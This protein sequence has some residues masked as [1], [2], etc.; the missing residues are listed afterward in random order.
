MWII[1]GENNSADKV[2]SY[3]TN[4]DNWTVE[5]SLLKGRKQASCWVFEDYLFV[6]GGKDVN[7]TILDSIECYD[8]R[9]ETWYNWGQLPNPITGCA[10]FVVGDLLHIFDGVGNAG[11]L[12]LDLNKSTTNLNDIYFQDLNTTSP[13]QAEV[14]DGSV[15]ASKMADGSVTSSKIANQSINSSKVTKG[16]IGIYQLNDKV[17]KYLKPEITT[18]PQAQSQTVYADSNV[19]FSV[20]AEGKYLSYQWKKNG[21]NL[22]GETNSTMTITDANATQHDGNYSVVVSNDFGSV[23]SSLVEIKVT[24]SLLNGLVGW[25]KFDETNGTVAYDSSGN[26]NDGNLTN[27]PTWVSGK[28]GGALSFDGINDYILTPLKGRRNIDITWSLWIKTQTTI[29]GMIGVS[30]NTWSG[31]GQSFSISSGKPKIDACQVSSRT[32]NN[33]VSTNTWTHCLFAVENS[34]SV[35]VFVNGNISIDSAMDWFKYDGTSF[36]MRIGHIPTQGGYYSGLIDDVR[37]YDR[38]LP[39]AEV[40]ALYNLGQ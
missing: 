21:S 33:L 7:G 14:A 25:W 10:A 18:Q 16:A 39:A 38:A 12:T 35:K 8:P 31:G 34:G 3:H 40:Q 36:L 11:V 2:E 29:G 37:I 24:D 19:S 27:G 20:T 17:L 5:K 32:G 26:G 22:T 23:E 1:G 13:V 4:N 15:T 28:I 30:E 9:T 6:G